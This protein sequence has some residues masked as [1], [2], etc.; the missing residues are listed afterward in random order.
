MA[1]DDTIQAV[2]VCLPPDLN[3]AVQAAAR[4]T[5]QSIADTIRTA[6]CRYYETP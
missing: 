6:L 4:A 3:H 2:I 1:A 5:R